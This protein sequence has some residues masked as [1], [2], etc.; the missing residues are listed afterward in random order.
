ML[1]QTLARSI[2]SADQRLVLLA[3]P[4]TVISPVFESTELN[5]GRHAELLTQ[6][7]RLRGSVYLQD[8]AVESRE[9]TAD[10]RHRMPEDEKSWHILM[11]DE[12]GKVTACIWYMAHAP[13]VSSFDGLRLRH[14]PLLSDPT[15]GDRLRLA[16]EHDLETAQREGIG[17]SEAGGWAVAKDSA[18]ISEGLVLALGCF[19]LSRALGDTLCVSTATVRHCSS[20]ILRRLGGSDLRADGHILPTYYDPR[21]R[22]EIELLRFDSRHA[23]PKYAGFVEMLRHKLTSA[24]VL[25]R[26]P[27]QVMSTSALRLEA[28]APRVSLGSTRVVA[29]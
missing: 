2:E 5:P 8:G 27:S 28:A 15:W 13:K 12:S 1:T 25:V 7:Q 14:C 16:I 18:C 4:T 9:L 21:Y 3:P 29:A 26:E 20:T 23:S 6:M 17:Y 10:G 22:C 11:V 24:L 19:S